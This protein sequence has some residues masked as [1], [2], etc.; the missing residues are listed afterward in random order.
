MKPYIAV[1]KSRFLVLLQYR[2]AALAGIFTQLFFGLVRVMVYDGFYRS[3]T[4]PQPLNAQQV[5]TYVWLGQALLLLVLLHVDQ[6]V[7]AM[8]RTGSVAYEIT[9]PVDLYTFW[10]ARAVSGRTAPIVLRAPPIFILA[11]LF[12]HLQRPASLTAA[13]LFAI[14]TVAGLVLAASLVT[15]MTISL[16]WT[17]SGEGIYRLAAPLIFISSGI[18]VPLPMLPQWAQPALAVLPFRAL[19]DTPFRVYMGSLAGQDA[20]IAV[21][22]QIVWIAAFVLLGRALLA[23]GLRRLVVQGG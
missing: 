5:I 10:F 17:I 9:R 18:M 20:L 7:A 8:I 15:L 14:T 1:L 22:H 12:L 11:G 21:A 3:S 19:I 4:G 23:R 2:T 16:L 6:D 13:A